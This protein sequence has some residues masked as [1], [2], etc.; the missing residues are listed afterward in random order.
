MKKTNIVSL[1]K[2]KLNN[3]KISMLTAYDYQT[4]RLLD[5]AEID[6]LLIG[7]SLGMVFQGQETT[8]PVTLEEMIYHTRI[9]CKA[10][11]HSLIVSDLPFGTY[12]KNPEQ[13]FDSA[14]AFMQAGAGA[15]KFEGGSEMADTIEFLTSRGIPVMA[16]IGLQPQSVHAYGGF[17]MQGKEDDS[18]E[19]L[20]QAA[21][22]VEKAGAFSVVL[23]AIPQNLAKTITEKL[24]IPTIG[25][26]AGKYC[27]GQVLV[28]NDMIG[29]NDG[30]VPKFAKQ[31]T[32]IGKEIL[33]AARKYKE[34]VQEG[35]FP[36][37][38]QTI[39]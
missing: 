10:C 14:V 39:Q 27:D 31:Y 25:I 35:T 13:C 32:N 9:V 12:Q 18:A 16:H 7:D 26:G 15:V 23:E 8:L 4:A 22:E 6:I 21:L 24:T 36:D 20:L 1:Q 11:S 5:Q 34:E 33:Q 3:E 30:H 38:K 19:K 37:S 29:L 17:R 2:K 28:I